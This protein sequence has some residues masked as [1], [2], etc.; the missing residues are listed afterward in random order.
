MPDDA[1]K[2]RRGRP[3]LKAGE[4]SVDIHFRLCA[5]DYDRAVTLA[6]KNRISVPQLFR[7]AFRVA[8]KRQGTLDEP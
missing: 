7:A 6:Q 4:P 8:T 2:R 5:S 3:T 1:P